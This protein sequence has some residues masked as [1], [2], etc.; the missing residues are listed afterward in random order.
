MCRRL[1]CQ[2]IL[3]IACRYLL[4]TEASCGYLPLNTVFLQ[5]IALRTSIHQCLDARG[6]GDANPFH[7]LRLRRSIQSDEAV[8]PVA[9]LFSTPHLFSV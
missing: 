4:P 5:E 2:A 1:Y 9:P 8:I 3:G 7:E 6:F